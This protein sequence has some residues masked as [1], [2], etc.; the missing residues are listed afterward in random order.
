MCSVFVFQPDRNC[1]VILAS[2]QLRLGLVFFVFFNLS[3]GVACASLDFELNS[4]VGTVAQ[5]HRVAAR[6]TDFTIHNVDR[7]L[8]PV[9]VTCPPS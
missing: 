9:V 6:L 3:L 8:K 2:L 4:V 7:F 1:V 5:P